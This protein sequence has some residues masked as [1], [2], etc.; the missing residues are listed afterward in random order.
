M[1][2]GLETHFEKTMEFSQEKMMERL[3]K[4]FKELLLR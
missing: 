4:S 3:E 1:H 2:E